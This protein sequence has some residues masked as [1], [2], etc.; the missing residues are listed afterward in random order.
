MVVVVAAATGGNLQVKSIVASSR[1]E[2]TARYLIVCILDSFR[3][4]GKHVARP[5]SLAW[6]TCRIRVQG[7][8]EPLGLRRWMAR[9]RALWGSCRR[10]RLPSPYGRSRGAD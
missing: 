2:P 3:L 10:L 8:G 1:A 4:P 6:Q 7:K 5:L 9:H